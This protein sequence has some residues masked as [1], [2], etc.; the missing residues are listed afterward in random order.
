MTTEQK[1]PVKVFTY[2]GDKYHASDYYYLTEAEL[3][4]KCCVYACALYW[5]KYVPLDEPRDESVALLYDIWNYECTPWWEWPDDL[6]EIMYTKVP[7]SR[8]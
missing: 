7:K 3:E 2:R 5:K 4:E 1:F 6:K 8:R